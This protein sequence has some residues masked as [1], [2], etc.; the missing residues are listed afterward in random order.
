M[1]DKEIVAEAERLDIKDK[2]VLVLAELILNEK[3][4]NQL[5]QY[6]IL[7]LRFLANNQK[8]QKNFMGAFEM[9]VGQSFP[10]ELM[11]KTAHIL[12]AFYDND[13]VEEEVILEWAKKVRW[14]LLY[15]AQEPSR[16]V[17]ENWCNFQTSSALDLWLAATFISFI[18]NGKFCL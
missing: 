1:P 18:E 6:R 10:E 5:S 9:I 4:L 13:L 7:F 14:K 12:K 11:P 2:A 8:A 16:N 15:R 3:I 17:L